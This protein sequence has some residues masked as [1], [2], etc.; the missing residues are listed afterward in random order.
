MWV[1][2]K[3]T[4]LQVGP[5]SHPLEQAC[6]FLQTRCSMKA[7]VENRHGLGFH[8]GYPSLGLWDS[9]WDL[10]FLF[11]AMGQWLISSRSAICV[12]KFITDHLGFESAK[13][14]IRAEYYD[15]SWKGQRSPL[16]KEMG[17]KITGDRTGTHRGAAISQSGEHH[18]EGLNV[19]KH[20]C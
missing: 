5:T 17:G 8:K 16:G 9:H 18:H 14:G 6:V 19:I 2:G 20:L 11:C 10:R 12:D 4:A 1:I 15:V 7:K 13:H 3:A